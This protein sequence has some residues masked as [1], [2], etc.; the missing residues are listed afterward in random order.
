[1]A[2]PIEGLIAAPF[3][4][5]DSGGTINL[6]AV[7]PYAALLARNGVAGAFVGGTTGESLS[8]TA[9][10]RMML[11][12]AWT[13]AAPDGLRVIVHAGAESIDEA[14]TEEGKMLV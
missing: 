1:M 13:D 14:I 12:E 8:L 7:E 5:M 4:P 11:A 3:T 6:D 9:E 10:E 2:E